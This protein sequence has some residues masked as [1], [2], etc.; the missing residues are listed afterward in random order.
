MEVEI[1]DDH[2]PRP[3][4]TAVEDVVGIHVNEASFGS[5]DDEAAVVESEAAGAQAVAIEDG[6]HLVSIGECQ[7]GR[8]VPRLDA[9]TAVLQKRRRVARVCRRYDHAN[10]FA[11]GAT[12]VSEK[13]DDFI[14]RGGVRAALREHGI[15]I[16][17]EGGGTGFHARAITPDGVDFAVVGQGAKGLRSLPRGEN[18]GGVSLVEE[19][20][21]R[22]EVGV[23]E[24]GVKLR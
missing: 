14:E 8:A 4:A 11:N 23:S 17:R 20:E 24:V 12:V 21:G 2:L 7:R 15:D 3:E 10:R 22:F 13:I 6:A 5:G 18:V 9:V 19:R 1:G 16:E